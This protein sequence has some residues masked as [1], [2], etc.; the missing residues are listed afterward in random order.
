MGVP[1][2]PKSVDLSFAFGLKPERAVDYMKSKGYTFSWRWEETL[3]AAHA[4]AFTVA[5]VARMDV[6][7]DIRGMVEKSI[8]DGLTFEQ[9]RKELTPMLQKKGWW[10]EK[11]VSRPDGTVEK[12]LEGSPRRLKTIYNQNLFTAYSAGREEQ[13]QQNK[14]FRPYGMYVAVR[15]RKTRATHLALHG[16][17]YPLDDAFWKAFTP[18]IDWNCRCRKRALSQRYIERNNIKVLSSEGKLEKTD[19]LVSTTTGEIRQVT[20]VTLPGGKKVSTGIGFDYNP[21]SAAWQ[22][23]LDSYDADIARKYLEGAVTGPDFARF[24]TGNVDGNFPVGMVDDA[25]GI[26]SESRVIKFSE[27]SLKK[28][29]GQLARSAGHPEIPFETYHRLPELFS[30]AQL[31]IK[32]SDNTYQFFHEKNGLYFASVK[33]TESGEIFLQTF[34]KSST[35]YAKAQ[36]RAGQVLKNELF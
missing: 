5:K 10:G 36:I 21:A 15:D 4:K 29:R 14:R 6:L 7:Q 35:R 32:R 19:A 33:V 24:F 1:A 30:D 27:D 8:E 11:F 16:K 31:I 13:F 3:G 25:L 28:N 12:I 26:S 18:P 2:L 34:F 23:D 20:T 22:P 17:V 9:F